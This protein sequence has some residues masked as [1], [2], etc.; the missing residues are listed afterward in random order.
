MKLKKKK[1]EIFYGSNLKNDVE[2]KN[3]DGDLIEVDLE[4]EYVN[5]V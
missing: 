5:L 3:E 1:K 2:N 4:M